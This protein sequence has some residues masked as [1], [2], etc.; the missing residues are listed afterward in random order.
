MSKKE[1]D[2]FPEIKIDGNIATWD[3]AAQGIINGT[4]TGQFKFRC[5]LT[6][7]QQIAAGRD[8]REL[9]GANAALASEHET[10]IAYGLSQ[11]KYRV[12]SAPPFWSAG[13]SEFMGDIA[14]ENII[15]LVLNAAI[16][17]ELKYKEIMQ[18]RQKDA[19][20]KARDAAEQIKNSN[21]EDDEESDEEE[22]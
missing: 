3:I 15:S 16:N 10:F 2:K 11:L 17:S 5:Y 22:G 8:Y 9:I 13:L 18:I 14:D 6:P 7:L 20:K 19:I 1:K 21:N 12:I 4:Y